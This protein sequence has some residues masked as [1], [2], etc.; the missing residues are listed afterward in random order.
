MVTTIFYHKTLIL[1]GPALQPQTHM[2]HFYVVYM[3]LVSHVTAL[4][5]ELCPPNIYKARNSG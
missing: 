5:R 3:W 2:Y 1:E 4:V